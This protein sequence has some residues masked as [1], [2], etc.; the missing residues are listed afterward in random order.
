MEQSTKAR[1]EESLDEIAPPEAR[2][3]HQSM[4]L[5]LICAKTSPPDK[6]TAPPS[7]TAVQFEK[8]VD[9]IETPKTSLACTDVLESIKIAPPAPRVWHWIKSEDE[10]CKSVF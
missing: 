8:R 10:I 4:R 1:D 7:A 9:T 3:S 2:V 5:F 6:R